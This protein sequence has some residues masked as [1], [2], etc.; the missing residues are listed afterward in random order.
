MPLATSP[1][2]VC[3]IPRPWHIGVP[4]FFVISGY[5]I[6]YSISK[7]PF[8]AKS[9]YIRRV[10]RIAPVLVL[11]LGITLLMAWLTQDAQFYGTFPGIL[12]TLACSLACVSNYAPQLHSWPVFENWQSVLSLVGLW[13]IS[14]EEQFYIL[15]PLIFLVPS[16]SLRRI[17]L[18]SLFLIWGVGVRAYALMPL[19][20]PS[21]VQE[22]LQTLMT[23]TKFRY[24]LILLGMLLYHV[25]IKFPSSKKVLAA[26]MGAFIAYPFLADWR[27][28]HTVAY[29]GFAMACA[30]IVGVA[31]NNSDSFFGKSSRIGAILLWLGERSYVIYVMHFQVLALIGYLLQRWGVNYSHPRLYSAAVT[32]LFLPFLPLM[33]LI[34]RMVEKPFIRLGY[35]MT[36]RDRQ[37]EIAVERTGGLYQT[38]SLEAASRKAA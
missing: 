19:G 32:I 10:C 21:E 29:A 33:D 16:Q 20:A 37:S 14:T 4:L 22:F 13:S 3:G 5:V 23:S 26:A 7:Y 27:H 8:K 18:I 34:H 38:P 9:F 24:D 12:S 2:V 1:F 30:V 15:F 31:K 11:S 36:G 17:V 25:P 28:Y 35:A 6:P